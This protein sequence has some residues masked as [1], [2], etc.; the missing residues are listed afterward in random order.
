[1]RRCGDCPFDAACLQQAPKGDAPS[2]IEPQTASARNLLRE[3]RIIDGVN[4]D[5]SGVAGGRGH[6]FK[7]RAVVAVVRQHRFVACGALDGRDRRA[8]GL[9]TRLHFA[10]VGIGRRLHILRGAA[11][12]GHDGWAAYGTR[13]NRA[14]IAVLSPYNIAGVA[15]GDRERLTQRRGGGGRRRGCCHPGEAFLLQAAVGVVSRS[16]NNS[17]RRTESR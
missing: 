4:R 2:A 14:A 1:M 9:D 6:A 3:R 7:H 10:A 15:N 11:V 16:R 17:H 5:D 12:G 8:D 13:R